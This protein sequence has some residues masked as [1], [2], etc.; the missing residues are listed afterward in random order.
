VATAA[1][2]KTA[3]T[4]ALPVTTELLPVLGREAAFGAAV[5]AGVG[6]A[7][8]WPPAGAGEGVGAGVGAGA[9]AA[10][11]LAPQ[12]T[13]SLPL[14]V[15][16]FEAPP[17]TAVPP[18]VLFVRVTLPELELWPFT[19]TTSVLLLQVT[20]T[21][22][23]EVAVQLLLEFGP[24]LTTLQSTASA[25]GTLTAKTANERTDVRP[26]RILFITYPLLPP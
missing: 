14:T 15:L 23:F 19:K 7:A 17:L 16:T 5:G 25:A 20:F 9:G 26:S 1:R 24:V 21:L 3:A 12:E 13:S 18:F 22:L 8:P 2:P 11:V 10:A 6:A 4:I